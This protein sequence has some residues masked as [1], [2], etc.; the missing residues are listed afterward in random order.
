MLYREAGQFKTSYGGGPADLSDPPG[1]DRGRAA[2]R[3]RLP[4]RPADRQRVLDVGDSDARIDIRP[5]NARAQSLD[6]LRRPAL[7]GYRRVHG[8]RRL[9][10]VQL[11]APRPGNSPA[12]RLRPCRV[13]RGAG[14]NPVRTA[15]PAHQRLLPGGGDAGRTVLRSLGPDQVRL[16]LELQLVGC[17]RCPEDVDPRLLVRLA[18]GEVSAG[19]V[20]RGAARA[21]RRRTWSEAR[22]GAPG[23]RC[24]TWTSPPR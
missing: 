6:R 5:G 7:T 1:P 20:D 22:W 12:G 16:V 11:R 4:G 21:W 8:R 18:S 17:D 3:L 10:G 15:Q 13:V 24:A 2:A 9:R 19:T 14:R 23:W